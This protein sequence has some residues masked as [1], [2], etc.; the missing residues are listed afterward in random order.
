VVKR[1][2]PTAEVRYQ[3]PPTVAE[4]RVSECSAQMEVRRPELEVQIEF[5]PKTELD[6]LR[7][8]PVPAAGG[9]E[10]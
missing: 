7:T 4:R 3:P 5:T 8:S 9:A 1:Y 6:R 2:P 10:A